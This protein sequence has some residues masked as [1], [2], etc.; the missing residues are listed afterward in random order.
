MIGLTGPHRTGKSTLAKAY[1]QRAGIRFVETNAKGTF[2]R[3]GVDPRVEYPFDVRLKIQGEILKDAE[4][5]YEKGGVWFITDRTPICMLA[6]T[7]A[8]VSRTTL[9][10][11]SER[12]LAAYIAA[13]IEV[14]NR[15]Y[16]SLIVLQPAIPIKDEPGKAPPSPGYMRHLNALILGLTVD[17]RVRPYHYYIPLNMTGLEPRV[18]AVQYAVNRSA[19]RYKAM[20]EREVVE[21]NRPPRLS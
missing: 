1:S 3:L 21:G 7:L 2:E 15:H 20:V 12:E 6:Y 11:D 4:A 9:T 19:E 14:C 13:C 16:T 18:E 10:P 17:E 5:L 8:D